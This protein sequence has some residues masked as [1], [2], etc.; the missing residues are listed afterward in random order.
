MQTSRIMWCDTSPL[1]TYG[2]D[3]SQLARLGC[4]KG[5]DADLVAAHQAVGRVGLGGHAGG[6]RG[7]LQ[8][9]QALGLHACTGRN[10][11]LTQY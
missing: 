9:L 10:T 5:D 7:A 1:L 6:V 4:C 2:L 8:L 11:S 3:F